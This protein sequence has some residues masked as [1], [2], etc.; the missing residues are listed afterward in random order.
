MSKAQR[1]PAVLVE[2]DVVNTSF[3]VS[4]Q[5]K[6]FIR[7]NENK[8]DE[9]KVIKTNLEILRG[10]V[11]VKRY[12]DASNV[13]LDFSTLPSKTNTMVIHDKVAKQDYIYS[14]LGDVFVRFNR[15]QGLSKYE[16]VVKRITLEV[17]TFSPLDNYIITLN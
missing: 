17:R 9:G 1:L 10:D 15:L 7:F 12:T 4:M 5:Q 8:A 14:S 16:M 2:D 3:L 13:Y 11:V 6:V